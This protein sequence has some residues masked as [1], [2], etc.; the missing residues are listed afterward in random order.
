MAYL[1]LLLFHLVFF[2][3]FYFQN[4]YVYFT[5]EPADTAFPSLR[6]LGRRGPD[7]PYYY[8]DFRSIPFLQSY[9]PPTRVLAWLTKSW[10]LN[11]AFVAYSAMMAGHYYMASCACYWLLSGGHSTGM[12]LFGA[13]TL[14]HL[15]Y[16]VKQNACI[17]C[18]V[19]WLPVLLLAAAQQNV[20]LCGISLGMSLL[21]GYWPL[22]LYCIPLAGLVWLWPSAW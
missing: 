8:P 11:A 14:S 1:G 22:A 15:G 19:A 3:R 17:N 9:Y 7:D 20:E 13:V 18:T 10:P 5:S 12:A 2:R 21:A 16:A 4:P 6:L